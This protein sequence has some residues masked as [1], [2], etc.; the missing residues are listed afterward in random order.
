MPKANQS[1]NDT[2]SLS[3]QQEQSM[4]LPM[5]ICQKSQEFV[6]SPRLANS[7]AMSTQYTSLHT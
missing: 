1:N 7:E 3:L 2:E 6:V 4:G 5:T